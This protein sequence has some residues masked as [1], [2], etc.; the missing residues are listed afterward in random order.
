[1]A[2]AGHTD[3]LPINTARFPSNWELSAAR[4]GSVIRYLIESGVDP[5]RLRAEGYADTRPLTA[6][7]SDKSR[8]QNRRVELTLESQP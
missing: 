6:N 4:A 3:N 8:A 2:V 7:D 1:M 5:A